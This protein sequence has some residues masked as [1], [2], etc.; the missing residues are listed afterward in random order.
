MN[1]SYPWDNDHEEWLQ[2][3]RFDVLNVSNESKINRYV[4]TSTGDTLGQELV[5]PNTLNR[6][7]LMKPCEK[8]VYDR[9]KYKSTTIS[10]VYFTCI[11]SSFKFV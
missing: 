6:Q 5:T 3:F 8:Y 7:G 4:D 9:S 10:E 2:C 1:A 11:C